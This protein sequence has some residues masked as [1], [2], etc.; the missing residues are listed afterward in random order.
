MGKPAADF[1]IHGLW[2]NYAKCHGRQQGLAHT[3]LS[4]DAL[5]AAANW[6]TL[7]CKSGCSL[8]FWS[9]KWKKHGTCSNL[10]QDEHFSRALVLKARYNLTSILSD[11]GIVPSDSGTYPLDSVRDAIAQGTGFMANLEC[12]RDAD[13][14]A[15]L[16]QVYCA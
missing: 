11:A 2:P 5:L 9:Y 8:E 10:E 12:N 1:G 13:G 7:S 14:E 16:F 15:Q 6:P 3:V 4:D